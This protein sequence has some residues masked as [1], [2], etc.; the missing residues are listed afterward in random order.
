MKKLLLVAIA[1]IFASQ[2]TAQK[3]TFGLTAGYLNVETTSSYMEM[4]FSENA[5]G[6]FAGVLL[7][8]PLSGSFRLEPAIIY[9]NAQELNA[10]FVPVLAKYYLA[11]SGF[12][13][14]AGP[15][16]TIILDELLAPVNRFGFDLT[17]GATYDI[18]ENLFLQARYA[19]EL[20][21]RANTEVDGFPADADANS[22]MNSLHVGIG[23]KF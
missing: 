9:G 1:F 17:F 5:S 10:L 16:G 2:L 6:F 21:N 12:S 20:T 7:D 13:F 4:N 3:T 19:L 11:E 22:G 23:Y 14:L 8:V 18:T 15:Q